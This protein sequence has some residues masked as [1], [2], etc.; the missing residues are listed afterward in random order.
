MTPDVPYPDIVLAIRNI[1]LHCNKPMV[2]KLVYDINQPLCPFKLNI[3]L[4][5][6]KLIN[7]RLLGILVLFMFAYERSF[8]RLLGSLFVL[9]GLELVYLSVSKTVT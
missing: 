7:E 9:L 5:V 8:Y 2:I 6:L 4:K 3:T 1:M